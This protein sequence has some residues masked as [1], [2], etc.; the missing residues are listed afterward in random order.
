M[1]NQVRQSNMELLRLV[2][3]FMIVVY[4]SVYYRLYA[5]R[6]DEP[7][8]AVLNTLLHIGVI[9][10]VLI[11]GYFGIKPSVK[12]FLK[13][14]FALIF[15]NILLYVI[16][17]GFVDEPFSLKNAIYTLF[18]FSR[19]VG[20]HWFF[21]VYA[22]LYILSPLLNL[23]RNSNIDRLP[24][25]AHSFMTGGGNLLI[26]C[27]LGF[28]TFYFGWFSGN[29]N[30][31]DGKNFVNFAF[32]Y[33]LGGYFRE[34]VSIDS[35]NRKRLRRDFAL[36]YLT[37]TLVI[38]VIL[39]FG[40]EGVQ[41]VVKRICYPYNSPVLILMS[42]F[43]F[44]FFATLDFRSKFVNW[45]AASVSAVYMIHENKYWFWNQWYDNIDN[46]YQSNSFGSFTLQWIGVCA[47]LFCG[48]ILFDKIRLLIA[49][50]LNPVL[51]KIQN[52]VISLWKKC[53]LIETHFK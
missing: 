31:S 20:H 53:M 5:Y 11:S 47:L 33:L 52:A 10:F 44:L 9:L 43:F 45:C 12:G 16:N 4:H 17:I 21:R 6:L 8:F 40:T 1:K 27:L 25:G 51:D 15:Y 41:D 7:I 30:L 24:V 50:L 35:C 38:G 2:A 48:C 14:Y 28:C 32:L 13:L 22:L 42:S 49:R 19:Q 29:P 3:M 39:F 36:G 26:L 46:L 37:M 34:K 23:A 18:P